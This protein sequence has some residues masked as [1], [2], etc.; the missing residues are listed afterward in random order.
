[1]VTGF[2]E[3]SGRFFVFNDVISERLHLSDLSRRDEGWVIVSEEA[4]EEAEGGV[5]HEWVK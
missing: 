5:F 4:R 2:D 3:L 1:M